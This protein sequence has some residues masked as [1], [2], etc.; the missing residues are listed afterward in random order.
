[1]LLARISNPDDAAGNK[2]CRSS[3]ADPEVVLPIPLRNSAFHPFLTTDDTPAPCGQGHA[4]PPVVQ[5]AERIRILEEELRQ[6]R[7]EAWRATEELRQASARISE[8][9]RDIQSMNTLLQAK[10]AVIQSKDDQL[11]SK[12][13]LL[14]ITMQSRADLL[15][16]NDAL[17]AKDL[18]IRN[19]RESAARVDA[20]P[21]TFPL[22]PS[23]GDAALQA[24][25][26]RAGGGCGAAPPAAETKPLIV[27]PKNTEYRNHVPSPLL[28]TPFFPTQT[29][30]LYAICGGKCCT[31]HIRLLSLYCR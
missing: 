31:C 3:S 25:P 4:Q 7:E 12:E 27:Q 30:V 14:Q 26:A 1:V 5:D 6:A 21:P 23:A 8:L 10:D 28:F 9:I 13:A 11:L 16:L 20:P 18:E 2:R 19:L 22:S 29:C 17:R 24:A 15:G